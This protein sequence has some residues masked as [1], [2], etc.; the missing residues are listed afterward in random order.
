MNSVQTVYDD[1]RG[2]LVGI[3]HESRATVRFSSD[4]DALF[5][6][7]APIP[8]SPA[9]AEAVGSSFLIRAKT[10]S[11]LLTPKLIS[12]Y[13]PK[14]PAPGPFP[15]ADGSEKSLWCAHYLR[16]LSG[17]GTE[18]TLPDDGFPLV[19][20]RA[21]GMIR[22]HRG[23]DPVRRYIDSRYADAQRLS[24]PV[25]GSNTLFLFQELTRSILSE[26]E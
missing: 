9:Q 25:C 12:Y 13:P 2:H 15:A 23:F 18:C 22:L 10:N 20:F 6:L 16:L 1:L 3:V 26:K 24:L 19:I 17:D 5:A 11:L 7:P 4:P 21:M 8:L 14:R